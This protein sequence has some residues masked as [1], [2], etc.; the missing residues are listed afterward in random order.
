MAKVSVCHV[1]MCGLNE[2]NALFTHSS[3]GFEAK[4]KLEQTQ[5]P[6]CLA[7]SAETGNPA[8]DCEMKE[9]YRE[10]SL[11]SEA[12]EISAMDPVGKLSE[13]HMN[14]CAL[15]FLFENL[16]QDSGHLS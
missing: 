3:M 2:P 6:C 13:K 11:Y 16:T 4:G 9:Q 14:T 12:P 15:T 1:W 7:C 8:F 10:Q 5:T